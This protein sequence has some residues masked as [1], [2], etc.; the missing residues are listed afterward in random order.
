MSKLLLVL[1]TLAHLKL[2]QLLYYIQRRYIARKT[3]S[4]GQVIELRDDF[5]LSL[6]LPVD[7]IICG[8]TTFKFINVEFQFDD[9]IDWQLE[10]ASRLWLYNLHYFDYL[11]DDGCPGEKGCELIDSWIDHNPQI[12]APGW[13][14]YTAS[15]R[16]VNWIF[17]LSRH[18]EEASVTRL[19]SLYEQ[20]LWLE[21]NVELH[22]LANHYFE[23]LKA[24]AFAGL[25][26]SGPDAERW[27]SYSQQNLIEQVREQFLEDGGH[28][29][30]SPMYHSIMLENCLD[31][32]NLYSG[33]KY[34]DSSLMAELFSQQVVASLSHLEG[35]VLPGEILP[36]FNDSAGGIA[37]GLGELQGYWHRLQ[38]GVVDP[39]RDDSIQDRSGIIAMRDTGYFGYRSDTLSCIFKCSEIRPGYQPGHTHCDLLSY[40]L[41]IG[42]RPVIVDAR[43]YDYTDSDERRY[44]RSTCA[45]NTIQIDDKEQ[46]EIWSVFRVA[47]RADVENADIS[48][49][50]DGFRFRGQYRPYWSGASGISHERVATYTNSVL[51]IHDAVTGAGEHMITGFIHIHPDVECRLAENEVF[52]SVD[53]N[54]I[55]RITFSTNTEV[56]IEDGWFYPE[57]SLRTKSR[58]IKIKNYD[59]LPVIQDYTITLL[60]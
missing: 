41:M 19:A 45:H 24:L 16:I 22:I 44:S 53:G 60:H 27:L 59:V 12:S 15:L 38:G 35:I 3:F 47:R 10:D 13:E 7:G 29:E 20:A 2:T 32:Y 50:G 55:A 58:V 14:P 18:P 56:L 6:P 21:N 9:D 48:A 11:R 57:F 43:V 42:E 17:F 46:S 8:G 28:Y 23:N 51:K 54:D 25:Y 30:A 40:E 1:R 4:A 39:G 49:E 36:M 33:N 52:L 34:H 31:L 26:F 5:K 37:P